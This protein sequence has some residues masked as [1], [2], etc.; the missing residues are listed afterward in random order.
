MTHLKNEF[1]HESLLTHQYLYSADTDHLYEMRECHG[2][3]KMRESRSKS[4]DR[5]RQVTAAPIG[6][7]KHGHHG[8]MEHMVIAHKRWERCINAALSKTPSWE[9]WRSSHRIIRM[10]FWRY[11]ATSPFWWT[12]LQNSDSKRIWEMQCGTGSHMRGRNR[13]LWERSKSPMM[14]LG[15]D[16]GLM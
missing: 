9:T 2:K 1:K 5:H 12:A 16:K 14:V 13:L 8:V 3:A 11:S 15:R 10:T 6:G 4:G 7:G